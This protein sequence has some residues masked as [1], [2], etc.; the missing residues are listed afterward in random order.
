[1]TGAGYTKNFGGLL[2]DQ[3]WAK[4]FNHEEVQDKPAL[5]DLLFDT[6]DYESVYHEVCNDD[7]TNSEKKIYTVDEKERHPYCNSRSV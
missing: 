4:I 5:K 6:F 1:M 7:D 3:M 2:A